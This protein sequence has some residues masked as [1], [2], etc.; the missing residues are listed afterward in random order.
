MVGCLGPILSGLTK[1]DNKDDFVRRIQHEAESVGGYDV[2]QSLKLSSILRYINSYRA[3]KC[4]TALVH[5]ETGLKPDI[6]VVDPHVGF[7]LLHLVSNDP[8]LI[9]FYLRHGARTDI[10]CE[11]RL[12]LDSAIQRIRLVDGVSRRSYGALSLCDP[13]LNGSRSLRQMVL[14]EIVSLMPSQIALVS[15]TEEVLDEL[16][17]KL[18]TMM[19]M[20]RMIEVF[21]RVGDKIELYRQYLFKI[22]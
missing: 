17:N 12:P 18:E 13:D 15:T 7:T 3:I 11:G 4:A 1:D 5:G 9:E 21:E 22:L 8:V 6:N 2:Y 20:L 10:R 14:S 16:N 19:S